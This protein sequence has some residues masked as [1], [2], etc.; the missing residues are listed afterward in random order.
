MSIPSR[1]LWFL[2][3]KNH[4]P[5][6]SDAKDAPKPA[7]ISHWCKEGDERWTPIDEKGARPKEKP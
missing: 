7:D 5:V 6:R 2:T 1:P 4:I 3:A